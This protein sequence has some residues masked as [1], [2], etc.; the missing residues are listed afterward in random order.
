MLQGA[1]K[2]VFY[3]SCKKHTQSRKVHDCLSTMLYT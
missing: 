2:G 3:I 1:K